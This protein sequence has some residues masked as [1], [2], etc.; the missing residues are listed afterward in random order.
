VFQ[1]KKD[2][3]GNLN[4]MIEAIGAEGYIV[5]QEFLPES[6]EGDTRV[7]LMNGSILQYKGKYAALRRKNADGDIRSN[8]H[9]GGEA[10]PA[11]ITNKILEIAEIVRPSLIRDGMFFVGLDIIGSKLIE[12]NV[13]SPGGLHSA[14]K[15]TERDFT[16]PIIR[17]LEHKIHL[18][19]VYNGQIS[20]RRLATL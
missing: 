7:F 18:K 1:V 13:F 11:T 12:V 2:N 4:Q 10:K 3:I 16:E 6:V 20:N 19:A 9:A 17:A 8:L 14:C 5:A 15:F